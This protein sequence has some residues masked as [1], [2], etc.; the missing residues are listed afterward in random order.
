MGWS[1]VIFEC[2]N[3]GFLCGFQA[4]TCFVLFDYF[5]NLGYLQITGFL[6]GD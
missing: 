1:S 2:C 4:L 6:F 3:R 5:V